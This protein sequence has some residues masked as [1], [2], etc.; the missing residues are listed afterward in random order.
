MTL[1]LLS[2][3]SI[4]FI[5]ACSKETGPCFKGSGTSVLEERELSDYKFIVLEDDVNLEITNDSVPRA[6]ISFGRKLIKWVTTEVIGDTLYIRNRNRCQFVRSFKDHPTV[7]VSRNRSRGVMLRGGGNI[8]GI[9]T[10]KSTYFMLDS[11]VGGGSINLLLQCDSTF[12]YIFSGPTAAKVAGYSKDTWVF[13]NG[14]GPINAKE[15]HSKR[16]YCRNEGS[17]DIS[18]SASDYA[19]ALCYGIG[20]IEVWGNPTQI[21]QEQTNVG[22]VILIP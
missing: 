13:S 14:M 12:L 8:T 7:R 19:E 4:V 20:N 2:L 3:V 22:K 6:S 11:D 1:R 5:G 16:V 18:F 10:I 15:L 9:D 21:Y 17:Q